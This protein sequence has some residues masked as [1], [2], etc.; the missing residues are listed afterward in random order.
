MEGSTELPDM[1][2]MRMF[3]VSGQTEPSVG[4]IGINE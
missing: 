1:H 2:K 3:S 4:S